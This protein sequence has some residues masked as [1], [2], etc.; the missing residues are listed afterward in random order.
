MH[1]SLAKLGGAACRRSSVRPR[2]IDS[3][4]VDAGSLAGSV[5][6]RT[7]Y[8]DRGEKGGHL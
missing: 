4:P 6:R 3:A 7:A 1:A 8:G 5:R 2:H